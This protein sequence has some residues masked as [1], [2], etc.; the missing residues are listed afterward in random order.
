MSNFI[1]NKIVEPMNKFADKHPYLPLT[2]SIIALLIS[3][4]K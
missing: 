2:I 3:L 1:D 4:M